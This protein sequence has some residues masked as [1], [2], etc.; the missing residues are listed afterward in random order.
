MER[1]SKQVRACNV[2]VGDELP[3]LDTKRLI[4]VRMFVVETDQS[5][6]GVVQ[7]RL[8]RGKRGKVPYNWNMKSTAL[9]R[10]RRGLK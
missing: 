3:W 9:V 7:L 1:E 8:R 2:R 4:E 6:P 5:F 10:V